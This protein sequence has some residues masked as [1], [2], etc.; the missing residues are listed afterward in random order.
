MVLN[1]KIFVLSLLTV[2]LMSSFVLQSQTSIMG[3]NVNNSSFLNNSKPKLSV[4]LSSS[5]SS[6]GGGY[7]S[8]GTSVMPEVTFPVSPRF[9]LSTGIGYSTFFMGNGNEGIFN[10][11]PSSYGHVYVSGSY[12]L[13][14]KISLR[15]T[16]YKT[17]M[18][19]APTS[20]EGTNLHGYNF[21]S[22]GIIM[23]VEYK[24]TDNFRINVGFEYRE[25]NYPGYG[26]GVNPVNPFMGNPSPFNGFNR[27]SNFYS[28]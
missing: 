6:F 28:F 19:D 21:S 23:D 10:S 4:S 12:L 15:G 16:A 27:S 5:F 9:S 8:F 22:Q 2:L 14:E 11:A 13:T 3:N 20:I 1:K 7:N 26:P 25:Q 18:L 17:F 24:V